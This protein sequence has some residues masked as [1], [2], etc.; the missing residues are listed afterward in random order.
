MKE[1][2]HIRS[3]PPI[4]MHIHLDHL[5]PFISIHI[6][7]GFSQSVIQ[8]FTKELE[9]AMKQVASNRRAP[10]SPETGGVQRD[11]SVQFGSCFFLQ[12]GSLL[13]EVTLRS[14]WLNINETDMFDDVAM[15]SWSTQ[16]SETELIVDKWCHRPTLRY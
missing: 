8:P 15:F 6:H 16:E 13:L 10:E 11:F 12:F 1:I 5:Y 3:Y 7:I 9:D 2:F 14:F 4:S